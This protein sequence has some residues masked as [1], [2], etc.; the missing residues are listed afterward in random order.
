MLGRW[1]SIVFFDD[2]LEPGA[3][4]G[5]WTVR[6]DSNAFH[7][8]A[9][10]ERFVAIGDNRR[11][12]GA[13]QSCRALGQRL[14]VVVHPRACVSAD[15]AIG[16]GTFVAAGAVV[17]IG[18]RLGAGCIVNTLAG[19]DHDCVLG[20]A[21]HVSPGAHLGGAVQVGE[22]SWIGLGAAVRHRIRIGADSIVGAGAVVVSDVAGAHVVV[23]VPAQRQA[24]RT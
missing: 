1:T 17:N 18:A 7:D 15:A 14:A 10:A 6:G 13:L 19:V 4:V 16:D 2:A 5:V 9:D 24:V 12:Q 8:D 23:G 20:E 3:A 21:V 22:R 11:R